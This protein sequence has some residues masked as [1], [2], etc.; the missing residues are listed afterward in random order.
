MATDSGKTKGMALAAEDT[1]T[2]EPQI[3]QISADS[4][5]RTDNRQL[6]TAV[7][8]RG[9]PRRADQTSASSGPAQRGNRRITGVLLG[10]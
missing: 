4:E 7:N 2:E 1:E 9:T 3:S 10:T 6:A 8:R 5:R